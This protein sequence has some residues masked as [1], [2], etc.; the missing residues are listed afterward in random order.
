MTVEENVEE[1][2]S[3]VMGSIL[4]SL[5]QTPSF[6]PFI[7]RSSDWEEVVCANYHFP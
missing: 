7:V 4:D 2:R 6:I 3:T 5:L 1:T